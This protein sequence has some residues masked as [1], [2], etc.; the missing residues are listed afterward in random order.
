MTERLTPVCSVK[1]RSR[2]SLQCPDRADPDTQLGQA[3]LTAYC[4]LMAQCAKLWSGVWR[5]LTSIAPGCRRQLGTKTCGA[6]ARAVET[7]KSC[8]SVF[9]FL[10]LLG[11]TWSLS[12][13]A[14]TTA[15]V[16]EFMRFPL[17]SWFL[18][19][20]ALQRSESVVS[21]LAAAGPSSGGRL[22]SSPALIWSQSA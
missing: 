22:S 15:V 18:A 12:K 13:L 9:Y 20:S 19:S 7:Q 21:R 2:T 16:S 6:Y 4:L 3:P 10:V 17:L 11:A 8:S 14:A 5:S 1:F